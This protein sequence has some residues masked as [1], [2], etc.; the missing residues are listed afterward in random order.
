MLYA[1]LPIA[2]AVPATQYVPP[3]QPPHHQQ[4]RCSCSLFKFLI[5]GFLD[6][7]TKCLIFWKL[8]G[9]ISPL[10]IANEDMILPFPFG[11]Y[12]FWIN[13]A[14]IITSNSTTEA[15]VVERGL[16]AAAMLLFLIVIF[17]RLILFLWVSCCFHRRQMHPPA[18]QLLQN[19]NLVYDLKER[20][21]CDLCHN[22]WLTLLALCSHRNCWNSVQQYHRH[23]FLYKDIRIGIIH[24][25][26]FLS[27]SIIAYHQMIQLQHLVTQD[28]NW[29]DLLQDWH[30]W[31]VIL[32]VFRFV[33]GAFRFLMTA[34]EQSDLNICTG[35]V[36]IL[37]GL[38]DIACIL[39]NIINLHDVVKLGGVLQ[40][41]ATVLF[42]LYMFRVIV[43][44]P[45]WLWGVFAIDRCR[46]RRGTPSS[47]VHDMCFNSYLLIFLIL[48]G[49]AR[50]MRGFTFR[51]GSF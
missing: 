32:F 41:W 42:A 25:L 4:R 6:L 13:P 20:M 29:M 1:N 21:L 9:A 49:Q 15:I 19:N 31:I 7:F 48:L 37:L 45:S 50:V 17:L 30:A 16:E 34:L 2:V 33:L 51:Y 10:A 3:P 47:F 27:G 35:F 5:Y 40:N 38:I 46:G 44:F 26:E 28:S 22:S 36:L 8:S 39:F 12:P 14:T 23:V 24:S 43:L 18:T 11:T